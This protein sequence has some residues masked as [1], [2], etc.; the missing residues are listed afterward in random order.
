MTTR[1]YRWRCIIIRSKEYV[2]IAKLG[3][4]HFILGTNLVHRHAVGVPL[5]QCT[6]TFSWALQ[7]TTQNAST[8]ILYPSP[9]KASSSHFQIEPLPFDV[10]TG[11]WKMQKKSETTNS[12]LI[13]LPSSPENSTNASIKSGKAWKAVIQEFKGILD[14]GDSEEVWRNNNPW[15][16]H[17]GL[18][19]RSSESSEN[20]GVEV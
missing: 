15:N 4:L 1:P 8:L 2:Q 17:P 18:R 19:D 16:G 11:I 20:I 13:R 6:K 10:R 14:D 12:R 7:T 5:L 3:H 9:I